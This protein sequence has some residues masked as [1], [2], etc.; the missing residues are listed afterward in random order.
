M[1]VGRN[2]RFKVDWRVVSMPSVEADDFASTLS[3]KWKLGDSTAVAGARAEADA[4][5]ADMSSSDEPRSG[6]L[7][8]RGALVNLT[9][10]KVS[11]LMLALLPQFIDEQAGAVA[12]Q[13]CC[14]G[15]VHI[16]LASLVLSSLALIALGARRRMGSFAAYAGAARVTLGLMLAAA[17]LKLALTQSD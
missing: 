15:A 3:G 13:V 7:I 6:R 10:P 5:F 17:G 11:L 8:L 2:V 14:L 1:D 4:T 16:L 12:A 9:N